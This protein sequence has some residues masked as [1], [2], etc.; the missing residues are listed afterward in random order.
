[1]ATTGLIGAGGRA[2]VHANTAEA[3]SSHLVIEH[4]YVVLACASVVLR[5]NFKVA[6][7]CALVAIAIGFVGLCG[8]ILRLPLLTSVSRFWVPMKVNTAIGLS[9]AGAA[10]VISSRDQPS[11]RER[12][13]AIA[14]SSFVA[15][16]GLL[17]LAEYVFHVDLR[18]DQAGRMA[19]IS[20]L[21]FVLVGTALALLWAAPS[22]A[23]V[24]AAIA[25]AI[26][27]TATL[28]Y[29]LGVE[30]L[31]D[32]T[33]THMALHTAIAFDA[34]AFGA[35]AV[36]TNQSFF[37]IFASPGGGGKLLRRALPT[38]LLVLFGLAIIRVQAQRRGYVSGEVA[39]STLA[40]A[41][42]MA[43]IIVLW[44]A[45]RTVEREEA[46][47]RAAEG[48][49]LEFE[50][51]RAEELQR[52]VA[53]RTRELAA[54]NRELESFSYSVS[55]DLRTPLRAIN[56]FSDALL[57]DNA[58]QLDDQGKEYLAR[59]R[60]A[61]TRMGLLIDDLLKLARVTRDPLRRVPI[62]MTALVKD[63]CAEL[64]AGAGER[65]IELQ[66][67]P[68]I[69]ARGDDRLV[70][71]VL[72][73][74]LGNAFKFTSRKDVAVIS[75]GT[76]VVNGERA[77]FVR[78]NGAGFDARFAEKLFGVFQRLHRADEFPGTGVGLATVDRVIRRH[79]GKV[80]AASPPG[81]GA[82]FWFTLGDERET[83]GESIRPAW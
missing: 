6:A 17:T 4:D 42:A 45:A 78:D 3:S 39:T 80:W 61:A 28:G 15:L 36:R 82:T 41:N 69:K 23:H 10:L 11:A 49:L 43:L 8:W 31:E 46:E 66:I 74:L 32:G 30:M 55:H 9:V 34:L 65:T 53:V 63:I 38:S 26:A 22:I 57:E 51:T 54:S 52:E 73:N 33:R 18:I 35:L 67:E 12:R 60:A 5:Q 37:A 48:A 71:V 44:I 7:A 81:E 64:R 21:D 59:I 75:F 19:F 70:R 2:G 24:L 72:G 14:L 62:D 76:D 50:R 47:R 1:M 68:D 58:A 83:I 16:L 27:S 20:A 56:G 79:G 13:I 40:L 29:V 77:F 25:L